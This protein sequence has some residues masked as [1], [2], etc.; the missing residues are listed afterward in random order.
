MEESEEGEEQD[1][2]G[3]DH[4]CQQRWGEWGG[5]DSR[6]GRKGAEGQMAHGVQIIYTRVRAGCAAGAQ[7]RQA[8]KAEG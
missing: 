7:G 6:R 3:R 2:V 4:G 1:G 5:G 8:E